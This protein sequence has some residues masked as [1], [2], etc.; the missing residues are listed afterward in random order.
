VNKSKSKFRIIRISGI[1]D[2]HAKYSFIYKAE[3]ELNIKPPKARKE[4][5]TY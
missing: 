2:C 1:L 5:T 3:T 4:E